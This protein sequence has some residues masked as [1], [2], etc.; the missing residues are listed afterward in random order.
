MSQAQWGIGS[1][2][3]PTWPSTLRSG[4]H[5]APRESE[6]ASGGRTAEARAPFL[7]AVSLLQS[8]VAARGP[9][10][11]W[12]RSI[13]GGPFPWAFLLSLP[14]VC[15]TPAEKRT[16]GVGSAPTL[17]FSFHKARRRPGYCDTLGHD[18][19]PGLLKSS[20]AFCVV[21]AFSRLSIPIFDCLPSRQS[22]G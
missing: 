10:H 5:P 12:T 8:L 3:P 20:G 1:L 17:S 19:R 22:L 2:L 13:T 14:L 21:F 16:S 9:I 18:R 11:R 15:P 4:R 7:A 6:Q